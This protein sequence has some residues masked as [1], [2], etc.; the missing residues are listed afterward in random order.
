MT[1][2]IVMTSTSCPSHSDILVLIIE[3]T[4]PL[5]SLHSLYHAHYT[6][7]RLTD[8]GKFVCPCALNLRQIFPDVSQSV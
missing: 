1:F 3:L 7:P 8:A 5:A 2:D 4:S 6:V